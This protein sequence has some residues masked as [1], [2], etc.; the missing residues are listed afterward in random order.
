MKLGVKKL[1]AKYN[2]KLKISFVIG[3]ALIYTWFTTKNGVFNRKE[4]LYEILGFDPYSPSEIIAESI[5]LYN[6]RL[7]TSTKQFDLLKQKIYQDEYYKYGTILGL[8]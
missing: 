3:I 1:L 6:N 5:D 8:S 4:N 2:N 7:G